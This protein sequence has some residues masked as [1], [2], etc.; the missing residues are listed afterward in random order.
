MQ[1]T[2]KQVINNEAYNIK[3]IRYMD[4]LK[5]PRSKEEV[6]KSYNLANKM[7]NFIYSSQ[8]VE[9][10]HDLADEIGKF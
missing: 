7:E 1:H 6:H 3:L 2:L 9:N 10:M 8:Y 5:L 4:S